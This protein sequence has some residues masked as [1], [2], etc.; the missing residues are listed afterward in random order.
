MPGVIGN[1]IL[2]PLDIYTAAGSGLDISVMDPTGVIC[3][4]F[5]V[6]PGLWDIMF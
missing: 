2:D 1:G 5:A 3:I 6:G 4:L